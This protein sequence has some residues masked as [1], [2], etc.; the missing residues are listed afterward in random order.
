MYVTAT[1][2]Y[3]C[4]II[5][6]L[7][8]TCSSWQCWIQRRYAKTVPVEKE[9]TLEPVSFER[10]NK[11]EFGFS[12]GPGTFCVCVCVG[13]TLLSSASVAICMKR[14]RDV[15]CYNLWHCT[16]HLR[17]KIKTHNTIFCILN[18]PCF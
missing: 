15:E 13:Q 6:W 18:S 1:G 4:D 16:V 14:R 17:Y 10:S 9:E 12:T 2:F 11:W 7:S 5:I 3:W 8:L